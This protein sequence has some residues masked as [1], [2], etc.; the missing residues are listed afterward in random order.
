EQFT[1]TSNYHDARRGA[2]AAAAALYGDSSDEYAAVENAF[3]AIN[4][5]S[6]HGKP[7]R[8]VVTFP[9]GLIAADSPIV[10]ITEGTTYEG[11]F[12]KTPV[13]PAGGILSLPVAVVNG[14]ANYVLWKEGL[15]Q[16]SFS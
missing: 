11:V 9:D 2:L 3:A 5:G 1:D 16:G 15:R 6:G 14:Y 4:V 7:D 12:D 8:P 13:D 10:S